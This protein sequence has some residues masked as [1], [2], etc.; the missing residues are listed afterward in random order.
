MID[1]GRY[2]AMII[3]AREDDDGVHLELAISSGEHRG[4]VVSIT[5]TALSRSWIELLGTPATLIVTGGQP[6]VEWD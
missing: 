5:A 3:D 1:D 6:R 4:A 2:D